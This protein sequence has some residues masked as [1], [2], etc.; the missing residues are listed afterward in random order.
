[1]RF[2]RPLAGYVANRL[3][4]AMTAEIFRLLDEEGIA[5]EVIDES[6]RHGLGLRLL[7]QGQLRKADYTGLELVAKALA[8]R[9]YTPPPPRERSATLD[10]LLA[11]GRTG[12]LAGRG[13][14]DYGGRSAAELFRER[15]RKLLALKRAWRA[16]EEGRGT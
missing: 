9:A 10:R 15:D 6:I 1:V 13:F 3:Q 2:A 11:E 4:A 16:I 8:N 5:P 14:Y 7:L 12:V